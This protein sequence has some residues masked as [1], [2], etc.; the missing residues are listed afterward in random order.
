MTISSLQPVATQP[1]CEFKEYQGVKGKALSC[2]MDMRMISNYYRPHPKAKFEDHGWDSEGPSKYVPTRVHNADE[3]YKVIQ[4]FKLPNDW[5][6]EVKRA[7]RYLVGAFEKIVSPTIV[8]DLEYGRMD[9]RKISKV[10]EATKMQ[11]YNVSKILPFKKT[12]PAPAKQPVIAIVADANFRHMW[13]DQEFIPKMLKLATSVL[14]ACESVGL[15]C[16]AAM[17]A[18]NYGLSS[19]I[20]YKEA[21]WAIQFATPTRTI[22]IKRYACMLHRDMYRWCLI[23][24]EAA[25]IKVWEKFTYL[26]GSTDWV[27]HTW[28]AVDGG[29]S[30]K[31]A[32]EILRADAV[33]SIG[34]NL[35]AGDAE[36][37]LGYDFTIEQA[38]KEVAAQAHKLRGEE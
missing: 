21:I 19:S 16:Y 15:Q 29:Y 3:A 23:S 30:V 32:R 35:D 24:A 5:L 20:P 26:E 38:I 25:D 36:I 12:I 11:T 4:D 10:V 8:H 7:E 37:R 31:W 33:I 9:S 27:G 13:M 28:G 1:L 22:P 2:M 34:N 14:W 18:G 6:R 17:V